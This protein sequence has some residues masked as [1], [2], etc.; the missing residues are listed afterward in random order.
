MK[1]A[2]FTMTLLA[3]NAISSPL[4]IIENIDSRVIIQNINQNRIIPT[5]EREVRQNRITRIS[6]T[7]RLTRNFQPLRAIKL[8][9]LY[10]LRD[11]LNIK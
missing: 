1:T 11:L 6:R 5:V 4:P 8:E 7:N 10:A 3:T 2:I 9:H